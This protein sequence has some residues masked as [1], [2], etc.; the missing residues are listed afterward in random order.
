[1]IY[2]WKKSVNCLKLCRG[3]RRGSGCERVS[4][5]SEFRRRME[6]GDL[7]GGYVFVSFINRLGKRHGGFIFWGGITGE[8]MV[9]VSNLKKQ[10]P[11]PWAKRSNGRG[12]KTGV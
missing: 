9:G 7:W 10:R 8:V 12:S 11:C 6:S 2:M 3:T 1:M 4:N 5:R